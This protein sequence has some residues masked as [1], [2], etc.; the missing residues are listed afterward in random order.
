VLSRVLLALV[1]IG[2]GAAK[3]GDR[4]GTAEAMLAFGVPARL[5][6][7]L[8]WL[9]P[10]AELL[11]GVALIPAATAWWGAAGALALF[12]L[13]LGAIGWNLA[14]GRHPDCRCFG[15]LGSAPIGWKLVVRNLLLAGLAGLILTQPVPPLSLG[16][17]SRLEVLTIGESV[18]L[19]LA[20]AACALAAAEAWLLS[21]LIQQN[22]RL[23]LRL[24]A[25]D[26]R[27]D[28]GTPPPRTHAR[29]ADVGESPLGLPVGEEAPR[30]ALPNLA[31]DVI[32][33]NDLRARGRA[34]LLLFMD[35]ECGPCRTLMPDVVDWR[36]EHEQ[37]LTVVM[38]SRGT[39]EDN[40]ARIAGH[41]VGTVLLQAGDE[42]SEWYQ[43]LA[44]PSAVLVDV[45]GRVASPV[46]QGA[47][48]IRRLVTRTTEPLG[49]SRPKRLAGRA[50]ATVAMALLAV[51]ALS[52][53]AVTPRGP[54]QGR[55]AGTWELQVE[56]AAG[57]RTWWRADSAP[58]IWHEPV[59]AVLDA[60]R[61]QS[62]A[63]G[64]DLGELVISGGSNALRTRIVMARFDLRRHRMLLVQPRS[65]AAGQSTWTI[66]SANAR[67]VL[68]FNAGQFGDEGVWGWLLREGREMQ[69]PGWGPLSLAV[70]VT[71]DGEA[72][73]VSPESLP[74]L[75]AA[76]GVQEAFQSYPA[77][78]VDDG[79]VPDR[80][81]DPGRL[82]NLA[83]R[84]T[85]LALCTLGDGRLLVA[86]TRFDNLGRIFGTL[87]IGLTLNESAAVMGA[88]GC[89]RAVSLDG[90]LS[91]QL[92]VRANK[93]STWRWEGWRTV[94]LGIEVLPRP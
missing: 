57:W 47:E 10:A 32:S 21:N 74:S 54:A 92:L 40:R 93:G 1:L 2:A 33:L 26:A 8:V 23:I 36:R 46:A 19:G 77:L 63:R 64:V 5:V 75:R 12:I 4:A 15:Q 45:R 55:G 18:A 7:S 41:D 31:G 83:H 71:V 82:V 94:P 69:A 11:I 52:T 70:A 56:N 6:P 80:L 42:V 88:L 79:R 9:L 3:L 58:A 50:P 91:A 62:V 67:A 85:R 86:L 37:R 66:D 16:W 14:R 60:T 25:L 30:F 84:D 24:D 34:V 89:R 72:H 68:A 90:G 29:E 78:L 48:A 22:G 81:R 27:L 43:S 44:T 35:P 87:P 73:F 39:V 38:L 28:I 51:V 59:Q 61:W 13:F 53:A 20:L 76:R 49:A 65:Q 17:L